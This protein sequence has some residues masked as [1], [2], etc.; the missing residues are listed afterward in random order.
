MET[1]RRFKRI[2]KENKQGGMM[3]QPKAKQPEPIKKDGDNVIIRG[4]AVFTV[5]IIV[6]KDGRITVDGFPTNPTSAF[7]IMSKASAAVA[8]HFTRIRD[9]NAIRNIIQMN[10]PLIVPK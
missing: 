4:D 9:D 1:E 8:D 6:H 7:E 5:R 10:N 2:G 3:S